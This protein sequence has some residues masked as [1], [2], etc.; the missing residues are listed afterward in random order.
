MIDTTTPVQRTASIGETPLSDTTGA[1]RGIPRARPRLTGARP[2]QAPLE[3]ELEGSDVRALLE[4]EFR[5]NPIRSAVIALSV[6]FLL[7]RLIR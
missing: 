4:E 2:V 5:V 3:L 7:G 6:G 1:G